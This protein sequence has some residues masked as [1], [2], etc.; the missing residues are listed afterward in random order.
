LLA[1]PRYG[2]RMASVWLDAARYADSGGY[3]GDIPRTMWPWR[4][5]VIR[6][7][8][9]NKPFD[10]FTVEQLAGDLLPD[11]TPDQIVATGFN[12]NHRINDEDGIILEEFR[13]EYVADRADTTGTVWLGL[14]VGCARCHDHKFD[15]ISQKDYYRLFAYFNSVDET[16][17]GHGN[18]A[19]LYY[20]DPSA[21]PEVEKIDAR[22]LE[23]MDPAQG[24]Y[25]EVLELK[26]R[27]RKLLD[28]S[29]TTMV[30]RDLETPRETFVLERGNYA[31]PG[32]K[33]TP[34]TPAA[35][36]APS[37]DA[38]P[39]R[40]GLARWIVD[41][42]NPLTARVAV[43]RFWQTYF[44]TG[45]VAT[46]EDFGTRG[47][48]PSH[49]E[50]L[51]WLATEFVRSGWDV[52]AVQRLIVT[53]ATYRQSSAVTKEAYERDPENRLLARGPRFRLPAEAVRDQ[54]LA[55]AGLLTE[56]IGGPPVKPYQ[57]DGL[58]AEL[59][60]FAPEYEQST[61][62]DLYRRSLYTFLRRTVP[63]PT[64]TAFDLPSREVCTVRLGRTNTPLQALV[65]MNDPTFV[66]AARILAEQA[67][68]TASDD[69]VRVECLFRRV[70][71]RAPSEP[72][73]RLLI[74]ELA[75]RRE[76]FAAS[77]DDATEYLSV[78]D[79]PAVTDLDPAD[80]AATAAVASLIL[81]LDEAVTKE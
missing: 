67:L 10:E 74:D 5:W 73:M 44:G 41:P 54:A 56:R 43:N 66:E 70:L 45:L 20:F 64:L 15:P 24:E 59:V 78:G 27:R 3:Q 21:R 79:R 14:T 71:G 48:L 63:Q 31:S 33:V 30:M 38:P 49:P 52:K 76:R 9:A 47:G 8:N 80:L 18:A 37:A 1:S 35:L 25:N 11:A 7:Y 29:L 6:A 53:S 12:R 58:W 39:N 4:D 34:G 65:V 61:G 77:P 69:G 40:L 13:A 57:P 75:S 51:D 62:G 28:E 23:L 72:E 55:A 17:R 2:E 32:E 68:R 46:P 50:L 81:N 22:L 16:G 42:G 26:E 36:P 19:P 60:S